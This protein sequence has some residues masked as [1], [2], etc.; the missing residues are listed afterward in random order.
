M[1]MKRKLPTDSTPDAKKPRA[2]TSFFASNGSATSSSS[3]KDG[4]AGPTFDKE[5]WVK[6]LTDQQ[7]ELLDLEIRTMHDSWLNELKDELVTPEFLDLKRFLKKEKE[8][9]KVIFPIEEDI[10]SW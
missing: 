10:Y 8:Q 9:G 6:T 5:G 3:K 1:S 4:P 2:I 7:K